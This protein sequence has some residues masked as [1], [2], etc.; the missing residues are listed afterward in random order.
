MYYEVYIDIVFITNLFMDYFLIRFVGILFRC[1]GKRL[2]MFGAAFAGALCSCL[3]LCLPQT[4]FLPVKVLLHG[5]CAV[6]MLSAGCG[7]K[8]GGL[9]F[10]AVLTLYLAAFLCG[11]FWEFAAKKTYLKPQ[12]FAV[13]AVT[14]YVGLLGVSYLLD[15]LK[16]RIRNVYPVTLTYHGNVQSFCG[17]YDSGNLL[18]DPVSGKSVSVVKPEVLERMLPEKTADKLKH[19]KENPEELE[20]S[21][22]AELR[23]HFLTFHTVGEKEG[24]LLAVTLEKLYIQTPL[25]VLLV[26]QPVLAF[27]P[28]ASALS[29]EYEILL[30]S[31]LLQ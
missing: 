30:N 27:S 1:P 28:E 22:L 11:G 26:K 15:S 25:E 4:H 10:K 12:T 31:R 16:I 24:M 8:K 18:S 20:S 5:G 13:L 3:I 14:V 6:W 17:F 2:R 7:L 23:P 21:E 9:L 29:K 19:L